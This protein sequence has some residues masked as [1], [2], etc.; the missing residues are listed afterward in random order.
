[1]LMKAIP[2]LCSFLILFHAGS[3]L[4][5][6]EIEVLPGE[7][8]VLQQIANKEGLDGPVIA[9]GGG[10][11]A[12]GDVW[13]A[14]YRHPENERR[15]FIGVIEN[16]HI[17]ALRGNGPTLSNEVFPLLVDLPE[18]REI[19]IDHNTPGPKSDVPEENY[20]GSGFIALKDSKLESVKIGHAFND[21][22]MAALAQIPSLKTIDIGHS[23]ATDAGVAHFANHPGIEE[24][25]FSPMGS[26]KITDKT[27]EILATIPNIKRIGMVECFV[28]YDGG[29]AHLKPLS[30]Q[31]EAMNLK[32]SLVLDSDIEKLRADHPGIEVTTSTIEEVAKKPYR[33]NQLL[34]WAS[35]EAK[36]LL[37]T[38]NP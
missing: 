12:G 33:R 14:R 28:T 27:L 21:N 3:L 18:L 37:E 15:Q 38:A 6:E 9:Q 16:G 19:R 31:L 35:P 29:F 11:P 32:L 36:A 20:D 13:N 22:G 10:W 4:S 5:A 7:L 34:K 17:V 23:K 24:A 26:P 30:G 1:M 2:L 25:S 8:A